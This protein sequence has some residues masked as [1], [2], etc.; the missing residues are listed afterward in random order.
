MNTLSSAEFGYANIMFHSSM[1]FLTRKFLV[2][3]LYSS[4]SIITAPC[5][6]WA[7]AYIVNRYLIAS[8]RANTRV[9]F[10]I[11][12]GRMRE[13]IHPILGEFLMLF[14]PFVSRTQYLVFICRTF[15]ARIGQN[16][17]LPDIKCLT[18]QQLVTIGDN[19]RFYTEAYAQVKLYHIQFL[20]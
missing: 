18:D 12:V 7:L 16:V 8:M 14:G 17:I 11:V 19:V 6:H 15:G 5:F 3:S 10:S 20:P 4:L 2:I 1:F 13:W 9:S